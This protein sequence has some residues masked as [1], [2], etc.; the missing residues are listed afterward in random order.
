[1]VEGAGETLATMGAYIDLNPVRA[2]L[3]D[4]PQ[5]YRWSGY[6]AAMGGGKATLEGMRVMMRGVGQGE[7]TGKAAFERYRVWLH[8]QG[9]ENDGVRADGSPVRRG[10][11]R[12][13]VLAVMTERG[14][15]PRADYLRCRVRYFVDGLVLGSRGFVDE[16]FGALRER[17][18]P[19]RA[20]GARRLRGLD[21][22]MYAMRDLRRGVMG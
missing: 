20:D 18:G 7:L 5:D 3:V 9:E 4:D 15:V 12:A 19:K 13:A 17:F 8:G 21:A 10:L 1:L 11:T 14:R 16:V 2:N 6:G 22:G